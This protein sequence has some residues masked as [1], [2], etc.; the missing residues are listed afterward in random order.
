MCPESNQPGSRAVAVTTD[1]M[2]ASK[3]SSTGTSLGID[4]RVVATASAL[5]ELLDQGGVRLVFVDMNLPGA[6]A[7]EALCGAANHSSR[8]FS[9]AFYPHVHT[10]LSE[11]ARQAGASRVMPRSRLSAE[12]PEI[13]LQCF[14]KTPE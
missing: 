14:L 11:S 3:I 2:F 9:V 4:T 12:L 5:A 6:A 13:L 7:V 8:P 1:L 10:E